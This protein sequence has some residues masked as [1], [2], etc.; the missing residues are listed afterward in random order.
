[1]LCFSQAYNSLPLIKTKKTYYDTFNDNMDEIAPK[2]AFTVSEALNKGW[3]ISK[4]HWLRFIVLMII[5]TVLLGGLSLISSAFMGENMLGQ[6][7]AQLISLVLS[8][9]A[10]VVFTRFCL[11]AYDGKSTSFEALFKFEGK[12]ILSL[13]LFS[14]LYGF[15][16]A[17]GFIL[18]IVPGVILA[19]GWYF[20][21]YFIVD[22]R[23]DLMDAFKASWQVTKGSRGRLLLFWLVL[24]VPSIVL[25]IAVVGAG[26]ST[27]FGG[28][29]LALGTLLGFILLIVVSVIS[30]MIGSFGSAFIYR[31][32][33]AKLKTSVLTP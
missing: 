23:M 14:I 10:T 12:M 21:Q 11:N 22:K 29:G 7:I 17:L 6:L 2:P 20:G 1:M 24:A 19:L 13:V 30:A 25:A 16:V 18:L 26:V 27:V 31:R 5:A 28:A 15:G 8:A 32:L 3:E 9:A 4:T 33:E